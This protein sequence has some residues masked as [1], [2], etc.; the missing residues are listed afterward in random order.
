MI[1]RLRSN[2]HYRYR[3]RRQEVCEQDET[4]NSVAVHRVPRSACPRLASLVVFNRFGIMAC[5]PRIHNIWTHVL[6]WWFYIFV[7]MSNLFHQ[8]TRSS[9]IL[10]LVNTNEVFEQH[11]RIGKYILIILTE[12]NLNLGIN[13]SFILIWWFIELT[14]KKKLYVTDFWTN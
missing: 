3:T 1:Q 12:F 8:N 10:R 2:V 9:R 6:V 11:E 13:C 7:I 4:T 5:G 14:F